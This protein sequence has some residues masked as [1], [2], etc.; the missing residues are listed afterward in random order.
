MAIEKQIR[1]HLIA[2]LPAVFGVSQ[3]FA[4]ATFCGKLGELERDR[5]PECK[6]T[7]CE[8]FRSVFMRR[9]L[10]DVESKL[11]FCFVPELLISC[12]FFGTFV[13]LFEKQSLH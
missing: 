8:V 2:L 11:L 1:S 6:K 10:S 4:F 3:F 12:R 7:F 5:E 13:L 9:A